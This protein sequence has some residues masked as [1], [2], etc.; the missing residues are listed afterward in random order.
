MYLLS[1]YYVQALC[2][3]PLYIHTYTMKKA[4]KMCRECYHL[5]KNVIYI[6]TQALQA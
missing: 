1:T 6:D 5:L 3:Q 4:Q 2:Q